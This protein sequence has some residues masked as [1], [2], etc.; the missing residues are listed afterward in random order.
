MPESLCSKANASLSLRAVFNELSSRGFSVASAP[1]VLEVSGEET[2][3]RSVL[4]ARMEGEDT[5]DLAYVVFVQE[6][7]GETGTYGVVGEPTQPNYFLLSLSGEA[8]SQYEFLGLGIESAEVTSADVVSQGICVTCEIACKFIAGQLSGTRAECSLVAPLVCGVIGLESLGLGLIPCVSAAGFM[9]SGIAGELAFGKD[10]REACDGLEVCCN[11]DGEACDR[12]SDCCAGHP[13]I[14]GLCVDNPCLVCEGDD[15]VDPC[16]AGNN[17]C[18]FSTCTVLEGGGVSCQYDPLP[19]VS[20]GSNGIC[21]NGMCC[22]DRDCLV[23]DSLTDPFSPTCRSRCSGDQ[24]CDG[25]GQCL[26]SC[27]PVG[28]PC[29][30]WQDQSCCEG[31]HCSSV[32]NGWMCV[33]TL[34]CPLSD[35]PSYGNTLCD[36][37]R[38]QCCLVSRAN[39]FNPGETGCF[40]KGE[41]CCGDSEDSDFGGSCPSDGQCCLRLDGVTKCCLSSQ[42]CCP[43][44]RCIDSGGR[45]SGLGTPTGE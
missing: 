12:H 28:Q 26:S 29:A 23:C 7:T 21:C 44:G 43:D 16:A 25:F 20:C 33:R 37:D 34:L 32:P 15:C 40:P 8:P 1:Q 14:D 30:G 24:I 17:E 36:A 13:C 27:T 41:V 9:C 11:E 19:S 39:R 22:E 31:H 42:I 10:C 5:G 3:P 4:Y 38:E 18:T 45:C 35:D 2:A 6:S